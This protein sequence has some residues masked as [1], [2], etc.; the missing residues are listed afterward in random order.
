MA[1]SD[2]FRNFTHEIANRHEER[3]NYIHDL[4][5][6]T[7]KLIADFSAQDMADFSAQ[8]KAR[9]EEVTVLKGQS[10][11]LLAEFKARDK[12]RAKEMDELKKE[13]DELKKDAAKMISGFKEEHVQ[14]AAAWKDL[15]ANMGSTKPTAK[16]KPKRKEKK[17]TDEH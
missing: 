11:S 3:N 4:K 14:A 8:D 10:Q 17:E 5:N 16:E 7:S 6:E 2:E 12:E 15:I 9:A 1:W 13:V